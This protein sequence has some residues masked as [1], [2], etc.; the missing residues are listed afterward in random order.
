MLFETITKNSDLI[1]ATMAAISIFFSCV[2]VSWPY[3][4]HD[5]LGTR[6]RGISGEREAIRIRERKKLQ[7]SKR[8][9]I[10]NTEPKKIFQ[11][12][13]DRL[14]L[15]KEL[16]DTAML[17]KLRMAG[18]RGQGPVVTFMAAR[19]IMPALLFAV[20]AF[21]VFVLLHLEY[22]PF[23]KL[24]IAI[25]AALFGFYTP[26]LYVQNRV[27][28]RQKAIERA[29]P[30]AL[31]F[32]LIC[33]ESGMGLE[34]ALM[35]V[36]EEVAMHCPALAEE[37]ALTTAELSY[38]PDRSKAFG[39]LA[40]R[41]GVE[42]VKSLVI[43]LG[44]SEKHGTPLGQSLRVLAQESRDTRM[45][46]AERKAA[47]LPPKLTVPMVLFFLPILFAIIIGPAIIQLKA[48]H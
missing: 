44:Q 34:P 35:K 25:A 22:S 2:V 43:S 47:A 7:D 48:M 24:G 39:N 19:V 23:V 29:W 30:D 31:D 36:S 20:A 37:I 33:V 28:K 38:L 42:A 14:N 15:A 16:N 45:S 3:L 27:S 21:Y 40:E 18:F 9:L 41:T 46:N 32:L 12:I 11:A 4:V 6:M 8:Q 5:S 13:F 17:Q 26:G 1:V 10:I